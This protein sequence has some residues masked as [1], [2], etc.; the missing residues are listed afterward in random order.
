MYQRSSRRPLTVLVG[1]SLAINLLLAV[2]YLQLRGQV[3]DTE[4]KV[5]RLVVMQADT[6]ELIRWANRM[7][8]CMNELAAEG[9]GQPQKCAGVG[10]AP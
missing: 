5:R 2:A 8:S 10:S 4:H 6:N 1:V 7:R 9:V 3:G